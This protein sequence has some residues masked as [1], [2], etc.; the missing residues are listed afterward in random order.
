MGTHGDAIQRAVVLRLAVV[1]ALLHGAVD[2]V[3]RLAFVHDWQLLSGLGNIHG[4]PARGGFP[5]FPADG[6]LSITKY[7]FTRSGVGPIGQSCI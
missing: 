4:P 6:P 2:A 7:R 5:R 1:G 3:V